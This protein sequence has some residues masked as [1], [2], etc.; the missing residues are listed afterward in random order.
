MAELPVWMR[1]K[2]VRIGVGLI[3]VGAIFNGISSMRS[4]MR[5]LQQPA[6]GPAGPG[7]GPPTNDATPPQMA[8]QQPRGQPDQPVA[9]QTIPLPPAANPPQYDRQPSTNPSTAYPPSNAPSAYQ[10]AE[11]G[12]GYAPNPPAGN[13]YRDPQGRFSV[14]VPQGWQV[15]AQN[16]GVVVSGGNAYVVVSPFDGSVS[17]DQ[18]V[19]ILSREYGAQWRGLQ[20]VTQG[21][22]ML[23]GAPGAYALMRGQSPR[24]V[25][26]LLRIAGASSN[27]QAWALIMSAPMQEFNQVSPTLQQ[28]ES[29]FAVGR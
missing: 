22:M 15:M 21:Q 24:G 8:Y 4:G 9:N 20:M 29:S 14:A 2:W 5:E 25:E 11:Q 13:R 27:G 3:G 23:G 6:Q 7:Y 1:N 28:I 10:P 16:N 19:S 12:P 18:L 26:S 17:S